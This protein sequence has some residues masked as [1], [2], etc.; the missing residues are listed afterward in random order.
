[1]KRLTPGL[2][3]LVVLAVGHGCDDDEPAP[4]LPENRPPVLTDQS[5]TTGVLGDT[6]R[7]VARAT[8][9]DAD[10]LEYVL[11]IELSL[12]EIREGY[13]PAASLSRQSGDFSFVPGSRDRPSRYF[14]FLVSDGRDGEDSTRFAVRTP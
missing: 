11:V 10:D 5:D 13:I 2:F 6:L 14:Q 9:P 8:D 12:S 4:M 1:M 7:L 3:I